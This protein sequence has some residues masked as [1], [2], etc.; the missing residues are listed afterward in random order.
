MEGK[1]LL[2]PELGLPPNL[3]RR[4]QLVR[5]AEEQVPEAATAFEVSFRGVAAFVDDRAD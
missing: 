2:K 3:E 4:D 1:N 5:P